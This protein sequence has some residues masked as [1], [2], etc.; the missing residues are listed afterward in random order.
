[1][2]TIPYL[3]TSILAYN[4]NELPASLYTLLCAKGLEFNGA[5]IVFMMI[6]LRIFV[7]IHYLVKQ[8][9]YVF[10]ATCFCFS[11]INSYVIAARRL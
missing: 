8:V 11:R 3:P 9:I 2:A 10:S 5:G 1:M 6:D 4:S 7:F